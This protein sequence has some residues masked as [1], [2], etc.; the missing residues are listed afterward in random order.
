MTAS[1]K[2]ANYGRTTWLGLAVLAALTFATA[3]TA[4]PVVDGRFDPNEGYTTGHSIDFN[5]EGGG[6]ATGGE[7]WLHQDGATGN[8]YVSFT[9]PKTL[10]DNSYGLNAIGWGTNAPS[11]KEHKFKDLTGS[12]TAQFLF[13]D[14]NGAPLFDVT[15]DYLN[16]LG[17]KKEDPPFEGGNTQDTKEYSVDF[18]NPDHVLAASTSL[19][20]NWDTFGA[21]HP[22]Y[23]G[24]DS[25]SP[26][27][28]SDY[29]NSVLPGWVYEV[30]Y[31]FEIDG[32]AF[33]DSAY[34]LVIPIV[35]DSPNKIG[36]NKVYP[37]IEV[38]IPPSPEGSDEQSQI[39]E[40]STMVL[41][42]LGVAA[43]VRRVRNRRLGA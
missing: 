32:L 34:E 14:A 6:T 18:G 20:H 24:A 1:T 7:L 11:G 36:K 23:F 38:L 8:V 19:A 41:F 30:A 40:P 39:P 43:I 33:G 21:A 2:T 17:N 25:N 4:A 16:G 31:E 15:M 22:E 27:A 28:D 5:V 35:H 37:D 12:D 29:S 13:T 10:V 3:A 26:A 9:Q 42:G